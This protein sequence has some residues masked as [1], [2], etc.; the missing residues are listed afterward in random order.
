MLDIDPTSRA[1]I[2]FKGVIPWVRDTPSR[3]TLVALV[4]SPSDR[5]PFHT[6]VDLDVRL[7]ADIVEFIPR[8][9][10]DVEVLGTGAD[11]EAEIGFYV[12]KY[13]IGDETRVEA[14]FIDANAQVQDIVNLQGLEAF[15]E[16]S[17]LGYMQASEAGWVGGLLQSGELLLFSRDGGRIQDDLGNVEVRGVHR[18]DGDLWIVGV[19][20]PRPV[21]SRVDDNGNLGPPQVWSTSE[22]LARTLN[23]PLRVRDDRFTPIELRRW[24]SARATNGEFPFLSPFSPH[25]FALDTALLIISGPSFESGGLTRTEQAIG[26]VGIAYP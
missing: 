23:G 22:Q 25:T 4:Q 21:L 1:D 8:G 2:A 7:Y 6:L 9:A 5:V 3:V 17:I 10:N 18:A 13:V 11:P 19:A 14:R 24:D 20:N 15:A 26:P 12:V 16:D